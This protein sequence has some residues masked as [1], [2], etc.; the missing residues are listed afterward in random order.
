MATNQ[1]SQDQNF[2]IQLLKSYKLEYQNA[3]TPV[4]KQ[5]AG[6]KADQLRANA[7]L[8]GITLDDAVWGQNVPLARTP[9]GNAIDF[10]LLSTVGK[11]WAATNPI[12]DVSSWKQQVGLGLTTNLAGYQQ[13]YASASEQSAYSALAGTPAVT[14]SAVGAPVTVPQAV[15]AAPVATT[16][17]AVTGSAVGAPVTVP[18]AV[19]AAPVATTTP[20][21]QPVVGM[22]PTGYKDSASFQ[23]MLSS[24]GLGQF[25]P[26]KLG[27]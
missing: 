26:V 27:R 1:P 23:S 9:G 24:L 7:K 8:Q 4:E 16:T 13:Q 11:Q 2:V 17:P 20:V 12:D 21:A 18:Q 5:Q 14:G 15:A 10:N 19:A 3:S 25:L 22:V 6:F